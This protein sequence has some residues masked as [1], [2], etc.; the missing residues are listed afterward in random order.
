M[1]SSLPSRFEGRMAVVTGAASGIGR[2][3]A[4]RLRDEG[5]AVLAVDRNGELLA[6]LDGCAQLVCDH[7]TL[8]GVQTVIAA[9]EQPDLLVNAA[10]VLLLRSLEEVDEAAF[11]TQIAINLKALF[12][13]SQALCPRIA[14]GG[15]VVN[16][17]SSSAQT[18]STLEAAVY[19]ATKAGVLSLTRAFAHANAARNVRVN[20]IVPGIVDT[21]MQDAV[22][23]QVA[24]I[25][26]VTR[27]QLAV[28]RLKGVPLAR[29]SSAAECAALIAFLLSDDAG[30]LTG[31]TIDWSGGLVMR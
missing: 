26:G 19:A 9:A 28:D 8:D 31:Q 18:G 17:S 27:E 12:F 30:Y 7:S 10:G 29:S 25:R 6:T 20:A 13:L 14:P 15:A 5:A 21:P 24:L 16:L 22:L 4:E 2:A 11:D 23:D 3:T 1:T